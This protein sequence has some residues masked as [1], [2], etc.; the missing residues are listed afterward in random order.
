MNKVEGNGMVCVF[1]V[2]SLQLLKSVIH[3]ITVFSFKPNIQLSCVRF[4]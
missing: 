4:K 1:G 2:K 3:L